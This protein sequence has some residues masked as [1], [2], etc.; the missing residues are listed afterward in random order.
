MQTA[1]FQALTEEEMY[2]VDGGA[3]PFIAGVLVAGAIVVGTGA[4]VAGTVVVVG[5]AAQKLADWIN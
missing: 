2:N 1:N 4:V 3:L 5:K